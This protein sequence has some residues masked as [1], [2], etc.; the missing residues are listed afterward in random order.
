MTSSG[1]PVS[2]Y[3]VRGGSVLV[4]SDLGAQ[5]GYR[6]VF[7]VEYLGACAVRVRKLVIEQRVDVGLALINR[8]CLQGP[9]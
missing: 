1:K 5:I 9:S 2:E 8:L 6:T 7:I 3:G 4:L